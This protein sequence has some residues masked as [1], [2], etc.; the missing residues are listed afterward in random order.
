MSD[1]PTPALPGIAER[2][3]AWDAAALAD[4]I[5]FRGEVTLVV[6]REHLRRVCT[7]LQSEPGLEFNFLSDLSAMDRFPLEPR[8]EVNYHLLSIPTRQTVRL[9]VRV[10]GSD[11][12]LESVTTLWPTA[13]WHEREVFDLFGVRFNGNPR[14]AAHPDAR[15]LGRPPAA[16]GLSGGRIPLMTTTV[17]TPTGAAETMVLNMGPQHPST[18]GV[19]RVVL[20]L[21]GETVVKARPDIG[22]L[23]TG[24]EKKCEALTYPQA[25]TLTDRIDY[26]ASAVEQ[27]GLLPG[28]GKAAGPRSRPSARSTSACCSPN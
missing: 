11:P 28:G 27:P 8:F 23:H 4:T 16:Q 21:D 2:V 14:P 18:H 10:D 1:P 26:L 3:R 5:E 15:Q 7:F 17:Q 25:I 12:Q 13:E 22:Y 19:L 20:E 24:I 9:R 6:P